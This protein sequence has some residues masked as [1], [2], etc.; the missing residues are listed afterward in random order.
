MRGHKGLL[1][2]QFVDVMDRAFMPRELFL[3]AD[4]R[5]KY[6]KVSR[7]QQMAAAA[8]VT[9]FAGWTLASTA[10]LVAG[11]FILSHQSTQRH[12]A[13]MAYAQLR[14]Q[15]AASRARLSQM[16]AALSGQQQFLLDL[17]KGRSSATPPAGNGSV[18]TAA[19]DDSV[20]QTLAE[21]AANLA[22]ITSNNRALG[23]QVATIESHVS[24]VDEA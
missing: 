4:G 10:G 16:T 22:T 23:E 8:I 2:R 19:G 15:V 18:A 7:R 3:R 13:D 20:Q 24:A 5:V 17:V 9:G 11:G 21:T 12:E 1:R 14:A 6:I